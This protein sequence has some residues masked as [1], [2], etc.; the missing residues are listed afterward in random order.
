MV[1]SKE[2]YLRRISRNIQ[3]QVRSELAPKGSSSEVRAGQ[4][5]RI[6]EL[7]LKGINYEVPAGEFC[8]NGVRNSN[9]GF[10]F[11][12]GIEYFNI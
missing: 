4:F 6:S 2:E 9:L 8:A 11:G 1:K 7:A 5:Q 10:N 12:L 3:S